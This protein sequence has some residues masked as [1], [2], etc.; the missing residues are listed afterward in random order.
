[1]KYLEILD[2][3]DKDNKGIVERQILFKGVYLRTVFDYAEQKY[4]KITFF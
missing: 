3:K 2:I 4:K 1:M